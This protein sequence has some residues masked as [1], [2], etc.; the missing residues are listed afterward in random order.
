MTAITGPFNSETRSFRVR[1]KSKT[2]NARSDLLLN[3]K[4]L[5]MPRM[6]EE[7]EEEAGWWNRRGMIWWKRLESKEGWIRVWRIR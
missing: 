7:R 1:I 5:I 2:D 6:S 4:P 3:P